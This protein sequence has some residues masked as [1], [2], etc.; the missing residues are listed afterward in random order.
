MSSLLILA[1]VFLI[2]PNVSGFVCNSKC[3]GITKLFSAGKGYM[4]AKK[5]KVFGEVI[6]KKTSLIKKRDDEGEV[7]LVDN[8]KVRKIMVPSLMEAL[9][10]KE[11]FYYE[12]C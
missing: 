2:I 1:S 5:K 10:A 6:K 4:E 3:L 9:D 8:L 11:M 12:V 7:I